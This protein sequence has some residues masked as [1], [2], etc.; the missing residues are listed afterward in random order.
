MRIAGDDMGIMGAADSLPG[1]DL[2]N[3]QLGLMD[4]DFDESDYEASAL[5]LCA[6]T[7]PAVLT[8]FGMFGCRPQP[9]CS[10]HNHNALAA[11]EA[12]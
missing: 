10:V 1:I 4:R 9:K 12:V 8:S 5:R 2:L 7:L 3:L 6:L 11:H